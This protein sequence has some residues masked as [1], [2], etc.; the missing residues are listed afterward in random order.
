MK[1]TIG[2]TFKI[3]RGVKRQMATILDDTERHAFKNL[4]IQAQIQGETVIAVEKKKKKII[5][6]QV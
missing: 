6:E 2:S 4:M 3:N 5:N 1:K